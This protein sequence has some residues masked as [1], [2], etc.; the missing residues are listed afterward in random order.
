[1]ITRRRL[2]AI[3]IAGVLAVSAFWSW[4]IWSQY[5]AEQQLIGTWLCIDPAY[6]WEAVLSISP[7]GTWRCGDGIRQTRWYSAT[8]Y[9]QVVGHEFISSHGPLPH[10][11]LR[12]FA[13]FWRQSDGSHSTFEVSDDK[14][15]MTND[16]N[17][18]SVHI[19]LADK[20]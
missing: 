15:I 8:T 13:R 3:A 18:R 14:L 4:A 16:R 20:H 19:R 17:E 9:W 2:T 12:P 10:R 11:F 6:D 1:V 5:C 7:D